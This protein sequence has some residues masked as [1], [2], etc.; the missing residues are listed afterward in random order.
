[1]RH[2]AKSQR[3]RLTF[4]TILLMVTMVFL[5]SGVNLSLQTEVSGLGAR[6]RLGPELLKIKN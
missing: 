1:M 3:S 2:F 4:F 6:I 5:K